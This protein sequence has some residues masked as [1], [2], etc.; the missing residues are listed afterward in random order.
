MLYSDSEGATVYR[1][2]NEDGT[3]TYTTEDGAEYEGDTEA[4][5]QQLDEY[6]MTEEYRSLEQV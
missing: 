3:Y 4:L 5:T 1:S 2:E 6:R